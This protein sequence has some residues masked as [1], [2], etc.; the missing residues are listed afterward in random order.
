MR[1]FRGIFKNIL[2][3]FK[4]EKTTKRYNNEIKLLPRPF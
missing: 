1:N 3:T 4:Q 2:F